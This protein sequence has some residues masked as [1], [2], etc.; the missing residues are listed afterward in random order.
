MR[1]VNSFRED[2]R[3]LTI[4]MCWKVDV[5]SIIRKVGTSVSLRLI[6]FLWLWSWSVLV[7]LF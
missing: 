2:E 3:L 7:D 4:Q 1:D 6:T 5:F